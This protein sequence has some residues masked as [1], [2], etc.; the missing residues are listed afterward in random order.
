VPQS[1]LEN[2]SPIFAVRSDAP[3]RPILTINPGGIVVRARPRT[4]AAGTGRRGRKVGSVSRGPW[5]LSG[6]DRANLEDDWNV[7]VLP[8]L[9][10]VM[11]W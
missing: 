8:V 11:I 2:T 9:L 7:M 5:Q 3:E 6:C 1:C 10:A 4:V